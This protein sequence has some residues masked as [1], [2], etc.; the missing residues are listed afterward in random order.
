MTRFAVRL[1]E[2]L[3]P[4]FGLSGPPLPSPEMECK[5]GEARYNVESPTRAGQDPL[6]PKLPEFKM[7]P[8]CSSSPLHVIG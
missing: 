2:L 7:G 6:G 1:C 8:C 4:D 3:L 5:G